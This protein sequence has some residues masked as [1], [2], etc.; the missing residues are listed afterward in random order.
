MT[1]M[2]E[3]IAAQTALLEERRQQSLLLSKAKAEAR[4]RRDAQALA[5]QTLVTSALTSILGEE[6]AIED[7]RQLIPG[8]WSALIG[9]LQF[10]VQVNGV[11]VLVYYG[12]RRVSNLA[13]LG[14][15]LEGD[16]A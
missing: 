3:Q 12:H 13:D 9:G 10:R 11:E 6:F 5:E 7:L 4:T 2:N 14:D 8:Q 1:D 16:A 15:L